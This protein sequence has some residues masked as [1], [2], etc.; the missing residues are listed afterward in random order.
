M[1]KLQLVYFFLCKVRLHAYSLIDRNMTNRY[2]PEIQSLYAHAW[3]LL[4]PATKIWEERTIEEALDRARNIS[5]RDGMQVF[6]TGSI[7]LVSGALSLL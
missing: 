3:R 7:K 1:A 5:T 4:D 6:V 2:K